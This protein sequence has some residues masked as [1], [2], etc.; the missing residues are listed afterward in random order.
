MLSTNTFTKGMNQDIHPK[1]QPE[2][3]YRYALNA[4]LETTEGGYSTISN[5]LGNN[6]CASN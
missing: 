2:G 6:Y 3:S 4:A 5:E 1:H